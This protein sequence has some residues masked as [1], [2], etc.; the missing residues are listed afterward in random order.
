ML[1]A[2]PA[3]AQQLSRYG[4]GGSEIAAACGFSRYRSRFGLWLEKTGRAPP[5]A[6]NLYTRLGQL[7]EP[8]IRQL[9]ANETGLD[10]EV[11]PESLFSPDSPHERATPD[12]RI[13]TDHRR[14]VQ[15]KAL[16]YFVGR[17]W[18]YERPIEVEAQCQWEMH[19][20]DAD[21][22]DLAAF[23]GS[24]ELEWERFLLG[25]LT[26]PAEI[27]ERGTLEIYPIF[28]SNADIAVLRAGAAAF[29]RMVEE[30][31]QPPI[32]ESPDCTA[33][34]NS[35]ARKTGI[36]IEASEDEEADLIAKR[37]RRFYRLSGRVEAALDLAKNR[38]RDLFAARGAD[39]L[40]TPDGPVLWT[41][42]KNGKTSLRAPKAWGKPEEH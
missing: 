4:V 39:R 2:A 33:W 41:V 25:E 10:V 17:A 29:W 38:T 9:Y 32:D 34:L 35:K 18:K 24:D 12:G 37:F 22:N 13:R 23:V 42:D 1:S 7:L 27:F 5:F 21:R 19:V 36:V 14:L 31:R 26:D 8:R 3:L 15:I 30:D 11:P 16:G 40:N 28:R 20:G 6:G